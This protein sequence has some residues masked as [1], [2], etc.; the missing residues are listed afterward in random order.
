MFSTWISKF[1][2]KKLILINKEL[3]PKAINSIEVSI[4]I[5]KL[6]AFDWNVNHR[7]CCSYHERIIPFM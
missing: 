7:R 6:Q 2:H 3:E 4:Q 1:I 5:T